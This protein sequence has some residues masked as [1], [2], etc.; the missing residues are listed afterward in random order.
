MSNFVRRNR[1]A[2]A[3][4][5]W[6]ILDIF[7]AEIEGPLDARLA[8]VMLTIFKIGPFGGRKLVHARDAFYPKAK[9]LSASTDSEAA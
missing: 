2:L 1:F 5:G 6:H 9:E 8:P 7:N 3:A 4:F